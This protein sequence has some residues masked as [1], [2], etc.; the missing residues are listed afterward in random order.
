MLENICCT[1]PQFTRIF[2]IL[3]DLASWGVGD[4]SVTKTEV[5][6]LFLLLTPQ[7]YA[8]R[9]IVKI[10]LSWQYSISNQVQ[11]VCEL[12]VAVDHY[13]IATAC[14]EGHW[15]DSGFY[16]AGWITARWKL[17]QPTGINLGCMKGCG[18]KYEFSTFKTLNYQ[19]ILTDDCSIFWLKESEYAFFIR[20]LLQLPV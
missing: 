11:K 14:D 7:Q 19:R 2:A 1:R 15:L 16:S 12:K 18:E 10:T 9:G 6:C 3:S 5:I 13:S 4:Y 17:T 8:C 20:Q